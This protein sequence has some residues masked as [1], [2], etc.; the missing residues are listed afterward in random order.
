MRERKPLKEILSQKSIVVL[1]LFNSSLSDSFIGNTD[2]P[3]WR[4]KKSD[5]DSIIT[6]LDWIFVKCEDE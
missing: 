2:H 3:V 4:G 1:W 5:L 6:T